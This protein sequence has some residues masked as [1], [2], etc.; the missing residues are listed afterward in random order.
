MDTIVASVTAWGRSAIAVVRLSG[1]QANPIAKTLCPDGIP[2]TPRRASLR[3]AMGKDAP[4]D[5]VL[6]T[7]MPG[8]NSYTGEDIVEISSHGNPVIVE[9]LI[10]RLVVLGARLARPG[11]FTRRA[12]INGRM[13][14][15][16]AEA[17]AATIDAGSSAG[18]QLAMKGME[19]QLRRHLVSLRREMLD[20]A[21]E[22]EARLDHPG[23]D[24]G[25][26]SDEALAVRIE[27]LEQRS[28]ALAQSWQAGRIR[29]GGARVALVGTVNAGKSS[30]FNSLV[31]SR[32]ALVSAR[33]GTTRDVVECSVVMD[34]LEITYLDTAGRRDPTTGAVD[35]IEEAGIEL[36]MDLV[37][38]VDLELWVHCMSEPLETDNLPAVM[39]RSR[40]LVGTHLD[41]SDLTTSEFDC[42]VSNLTGEGIENLK[43]LIREALKVGNTAGERLTL[44]S[45][46]Q[47]DLMERLADHALA[48]R[49]ALMGV[50]G[51]AVASEEIQ[52]ALQRLAE[53]CGGDP[54]EEVLDR[55]FSRFC[56]GK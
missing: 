14:L 27:S 32:R 33:E 6:V 34:G 23:E 48:G 18:V 9:Q 5:Q 56:I 45:Q 1:V 42:A 36:G 44:F 13:D 38:G 55:L 35:P 37:A 28:R 10:D 51:P 7:W 47:H 25:L 22:L 50:L 16:Q 53:L 17:V 2:W 43:N 30:L 19:G 26:E 21:A 4:I 41:R 8:P 39:G 12:V 20:F 11:E 49:Q 24:L 29:V 15:L 54:R 52:F 46:R 3:R 31:G 40:L